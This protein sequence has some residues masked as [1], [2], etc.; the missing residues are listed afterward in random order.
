MVWRVDSGQGRA[1]KS[2]KVECGGCGCTE[3]REDW[4]RPRA[5]VLGGQRSVLRR[6]EQV[7]L[8]GFQLRAPA[9][10]PSQQPSA[11]HQ[12]IHGSLEPRDRAVMRVQENWCLEKGRPQERVKTG[13]RSSPD[14]SEPALPPKRRVLGGDSAGAPRELEGTQ[15]SRDRGELVRGKFRRTGGPPSL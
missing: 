13:R 12:G 3:R 8:P 11:D 1:R 10:A 6:K 5:G 2:G 14:A 15:E 7:G 4:S 9:A